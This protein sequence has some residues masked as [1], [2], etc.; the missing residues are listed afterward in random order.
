MTCALIAFR[1]CN[2]V[3][4]RR[5]KTHFEQVPL[6]IVQRILKEQTERQFDSDDGIAKEAVENAINSGEEA[7]TVEVGNLL[8]G[9]NRNKS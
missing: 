9:S 2:G 3:S 7:H 1:V 6:E 4:M 8:V 5:P